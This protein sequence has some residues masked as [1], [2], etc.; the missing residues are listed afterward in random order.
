[1]PIFSNAGV[2][3]GSLC[4]VA[5]SILWI[6]AMS[7]FELSFLYPFLSI[8]YLCI[9]FGSKLFLNESISLNR[10]ISAIFISIGLILISRSPYSEAPSTTLKDHNKNK[11]EN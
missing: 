5:A 2:L 6:T 8:N 7:K 4:I 3:A 11:T 9:I 1:V 10:Y